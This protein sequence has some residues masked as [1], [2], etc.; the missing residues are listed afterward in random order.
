MKKKTLTN[1]DAKSLSF[2]EDSLRLLYAKRQVDA[3]V[4]LNKPE[5]LVLA[6]ATL[7]LSLNLVQLI[8]LVV[9]NKTC[10]CQHQLNI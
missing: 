1:V 9:S 8:F 2:V 4:S 10:K 5:S 6:Y 7:V 3:S